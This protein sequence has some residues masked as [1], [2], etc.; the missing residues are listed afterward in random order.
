MT[1]ID[2]DRQPADT[3]RLPI[4]PCH[5]R[6]Q[7][8]EP[9]GTRRR[10][11]EPRGPRHRMHVARRGKSGRRMFARREAPRRDD[12][13]P[14]VDVE[15]VELWREGRLDVDFVV[16]SELETAY[17]IARVDRRPRGSAD[18]RVRER[19]GADGESTSRRRSTATSLGSRSANRRL[20]PTRGRR[21]HPRRR[22]DPS[23]GDDE[24]APGDRLVMVGSPQAVKGMGRA[25]LARG[26]RGQDSWCSGEARSVRDR[27][28]CSTQGLGVR[29]IE[30]RRER[31]QHRRGGAPKARVFQATGFDPDF[32]ERERIGRAQAAVFAMRDDAKYHYAASLA[33]VHGF[34]SPSR[35]PTTRSPQRYDKPGST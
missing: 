35:S 24:L 11:G 1:V 20:P 7:R 23:R 8:C 30:P 14:D 29:L 19:R 34:P 9:E 17:A 12:A 22:D 3:A 6:G 27:P 18:G 13:D 32:L 21:R 4:R 15:Y 16:S 5:D 33:Q 25:P 31:A 10:R 28:S 2:L 26:G